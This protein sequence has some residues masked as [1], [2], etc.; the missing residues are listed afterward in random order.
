VASRQ[1]LSPAIRTF[2]DQ[3]RFTVVAL[4]PYNADQLAKQ[5]M[6]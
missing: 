4:A 6:V 3:V 2:N 1:N 5:G